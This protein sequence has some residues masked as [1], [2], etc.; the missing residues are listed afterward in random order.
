MRN[1]FCDKCGVSTEVNLV[2]GDY[3]CVGEVNISSEYIYGFGHFD[4]CES[5]YNNYTDQL[6]KVKLDFFGSIKKNKKE[7]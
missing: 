2:D 3:V 4:L 6:A 1:V 5:C 7:I